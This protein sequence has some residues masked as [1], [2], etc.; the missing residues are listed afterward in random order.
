MKP[1][2]PGATQ[3]VRVAA[4]SQPINAAGRPGATQPR[5]AVT[6]PRGTATPPRGTA[7]PPRGTATPPRGTA[8]P[9]RGTAAQPRGVGT[10]PAETR[11]RRPSSAEEDPLTSAAFSLRPERSGRRP[12][13]PPGPGRLSGPLRH[14]HLAVS[15]LDAFLRRPVFVGYPDHEHAAVRPELRK[16]KSCGPGGRTATA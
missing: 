12:V 1:P 8:T 15:V 6:P 14:R 4:S 13:V 9:P 2:L 11:R 5:E 16:R 7:T 3:P 10:Q